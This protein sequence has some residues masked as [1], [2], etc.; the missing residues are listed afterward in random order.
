MIES[1]RIW[2]MLQEERGLDLGF[3]QSG[4]VYLC[5][6]DEELARR[7]AWLDCAKDFQ[8]DS[9]MID[10]AEIG[11]VL[12]GT[13]AQWRGALYTAGDGRAEPQKVVPALAQRA[14]ELGAKV[15]TA[16]AVRGIETT[17]GRIAAAVTERGPIACSS[18]VLAAGVWSRLFCRNLDLTLP[19]LKVLG[20]VMRIDGVDHGPESAALCSDF[21]FRKRADGGYTVAS[22]TGAI[23]DIVPDT[24]RFF[25]MFLPL[26]AAERRH[27][28][29]RFGRRFFEEF[30]Q[31]SRWRLDEVTPF[32][33]V[34]TLD[35]QAS[36]RE[37][38]AGLDHL[39]SCFPAFNGA[40]VRQR[41]A[42]YIDAT[43]D[44]IPVIS[45]VDALP[46]FYIATGFSGHGFGIGPGAG[47]LMADLVTGRHP[48]V[49]PAPFRFSRFSDGSRLTLFTGL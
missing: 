36:G 9:R 27:T 21:A 24:I 6:R 4:I 29:I 43:P 34:R 7:A 22:G 33:H 18:V 3:K 30:R 5:R 45:G 40:A 13:N 28:K 39:K 23:A 14:R 48:I 46:G 11:R 19:Q 8:I 12:P 42:G 31:P 15:V 1:M 2:A 25:R 17:A 20:S 35:P 44:A 37:L 16:C 49:D 38:D 26:A 10:E 47:R 41:W 32:E